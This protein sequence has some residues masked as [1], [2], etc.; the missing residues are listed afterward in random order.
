MK[1]LIKNVAF[2]LIVPG[3]VA[4]YIPLFVFNE[5]IW[6]SGIVLGVGVFFGVLGTV[7]YCWCVWD[8][9]TRGAG[10][11]APIAAPDKL[12]SRGLYQYSRNPMYVAVVCVILGWASVFASW[13]ML[14]YAAG[15]GLAFHFRV[16]LHEEPHLRNEFGEKYESYCSRTNRWFPRM[17]KLAA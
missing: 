11:P 10:T 2:T 15:I 1:L 4:V 16:V 9:A 17:G 8:F 12:V 14:I 7:L 13:S 5:H 6:S 3:T